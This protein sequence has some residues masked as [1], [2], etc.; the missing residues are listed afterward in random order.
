MPYKGAVPLPVLMMR[1]EQG[2]EETAVA[3]YTISSWNTNYALPFYCVIPSGG[4][5]GVDVAG[6]LEENLHGILDHGGTADDIR[7]VLGLVPRDELDE[8]TLA[9]ED[10]TEIDLGYCIEGQLLTF[11]EM[12]PDATDP[13]SFLSEKQVSQLKGMLESVPAGSQIR[14]AELLVGSDFTDWQAFAICKAFREGLDAGTVGKIADTR[15]NHS[16]MRELARIAEELL[17]SVLDACLNPEFSAEKLHLI[18]CIVQNGGRDLPWRELSEAQLDVAAGALS[19]GLPVPLVELFA[20]PQIPAANMRSV[21]A[22][23]YDGVERAT[24]LRM[25]DPAYTPDQLACVRLTGEYNL[26]PGQ[27]KALFGPEV[28]APAMRA[29]AYALGDLSLPPAGV[30][31]LAQDPLRFSG[32][33]LRVLYDSMA[34]PQLSQE[35]VEVI[36]DPALTPQQ[37]QQ[38]CVQ[39]EGAGDA[40]SVQHLKDSFG[41]RSGTREAEK[42]SMREITGAAREASSEIAGGRSVDTD[43][44]R[45]PER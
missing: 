41:V 32:E 25:L 30:L 37:M 44:E 39:C 27:F 23:L 40:Q 1:L 31:R 24:V 19:L 6:I 26:T 17:P 7:Q 18:R 38:L 16:Q 34:N 28:P 36:A 11:D 20:K 13:G 4:A 35:V 22:A 15:F 2:L 29:I 43:G 9:E 42:G 3:Q 8:D 45:N 5:F 33:Q 10:Y 21:F 12:D 14:A